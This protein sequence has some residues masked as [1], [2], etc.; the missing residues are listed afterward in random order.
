MRKY[1]EG[2][3]PDY[4]VII[5]KIR[6]RR[7]RSSGFSNS[8]ANIIRIKFNPLSF[9]GAGSEQEWRIFV[10]T[11][12]NYWDVWDMYMSDKHKIK[13]SLSYFKGK[14]ANDWVTIKE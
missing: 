12:D 8:G 13:K 3:D 5:G 4:M 11:F 7:R 6:K 1:L 14:T 9:Y 2:E 10:N